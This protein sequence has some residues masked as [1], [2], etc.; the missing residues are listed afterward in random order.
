MRAN[1]WSDGYFRF[2]PEEL[3]RL[4]TAYR[5]SLSHQGAICGGLDRLFVL[6]KVSR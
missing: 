3:D 5:P 6:D 2:T 4:F 1:D